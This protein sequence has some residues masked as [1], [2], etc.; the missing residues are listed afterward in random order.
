[1]PYI[2]ISTRIR[3]ELG[4]TL[5]GDEW[6][7]PE[8]MALLDAEL[9]HQFGN[10]FKEYLSKHPPRVVLNKLGKIGYKVISST[11]IGQTIVWTLFKPDEDQ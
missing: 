7:D 5:C 6:S 11:G 3:L 4:P 10:N 8:L 1:M 9:V 2:L